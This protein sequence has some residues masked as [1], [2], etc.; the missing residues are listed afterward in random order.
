M[1]LWLAVNQ[2]KRLQYGRYIC[3]TWNLWGP[4]AEDD[5][6]KLLTFRIV[7]VREATPPMN[8]QPYDPEVV[9]IGRA[10]V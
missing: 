1:N 8:Q 3:R 4:G 2:D 7:F 9:E 10:H 6:Y 5:S